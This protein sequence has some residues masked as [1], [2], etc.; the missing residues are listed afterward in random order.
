MLVRTQRGDAEGLF[1]WHWVLTDSLEIFCDVVQH[2]YR[3]P[4]KTLRWLQ[5]TYPEGY[6]LYAVALASMEHP[7]LAA[8]IAYIEEVWQDVRPTGSDTP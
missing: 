3:G 5:E 2:P 7:A 6:A 4:K 8:W 1:R